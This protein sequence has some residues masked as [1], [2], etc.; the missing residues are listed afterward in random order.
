VL[1]TYLLWLTPLHH[2]IPNWR[3]LVPFLACASFYI[4]AGLFLLILG[5]GLVSRWAVLI[6]VIVT[7]VLSSL[8]S[9]SL[10]A[11]NLYDATNPSRAHVRDVAAVVAK[12]VHWANSIDGGAAEAT[13]FAGMAFLEEAV[14]L[15]PV[16]VLIARRRIRMPHGAMLCG[17]L[18][19]LTFGVVEAV[20]YGYLI[21]PGSHQTVTTYLTRFLVMAP[22]HGVWDGLAAGLVFFLSGTWRG[23][24]ERRPKFG[25]FAAAY[26]AATMFH[27]VHNALQKNYGAE[28]QIGT[29][30][31][32]LAPLYL[33]SRSARRRS[34]A[35][36]QPLELPFIGDLH[37][38]M[39]SMATWFLAVSM[40]FCWVM[41]LA[42]TA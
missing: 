19:G 42:P 34:E 23:D 5:R 6:S 8:L 25:A 22:M 10:R 36:G 37:L 2:A 7:F 38:L 33:M 4:C 35:M 27:V 26:T 12:A 28:T 14:K 29:V 20:T 9:V 24:V 21:Y 17:A 15:F 41:G 32:L 13:R 11:Q 3:T 18:S 30:F 31:V 16:F 1:G 40:L 39:I